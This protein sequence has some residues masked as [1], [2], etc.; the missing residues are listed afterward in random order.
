LSASYLFI[1]LLHHHHLHTPIFP[2]PSLIR[3]RDFWGHS[4][5]EDP[6]PSTPL[7]KIPVRPP[8]QNKVRVLTIKAS[9]L[10][11]PL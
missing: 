2:F 3:F 4:K 9:V 7:I 1:Y 10:T 6:K 8:T 11:S 5:L